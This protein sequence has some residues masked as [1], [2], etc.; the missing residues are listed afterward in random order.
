MNIGVH[1]S[2]QMSVFVLFGFIPRS[3]TAG[4][5]GNSI[6]QCFEETPCCFP[7][8]LYL[9]TFSPTVQGSFLSISSPVFII[10]T[11]ICLFNNSHSDKYLIFV[12]ICVSLMINNIENLFM[13]LFAICISSL[14]KYLFRSSAKFLMG[15]FIFYILSC[16]SCIHAGILNPCQ[17]YNFQIF[18]PIQQVVF[19]FCQWFS[20]LCKKF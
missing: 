13:C 6:F 12:L 18:S 17:S 7:P 19:L 8:C 9:F 11:N 5:Y 10:I 2:F 3:R 14:E 20:L 15:L 16:M 4:S 1:V